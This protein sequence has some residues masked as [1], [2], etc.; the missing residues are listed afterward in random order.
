MGAD[1]GS[2]YN[3]DAEADADDAIAEFLHGQGPTDPRTGMRKKFE[4][5]YMNWFLPADQ[6]KRYSVPSKL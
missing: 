2:I 3:Y 6:N 5:V 4:D 1:C